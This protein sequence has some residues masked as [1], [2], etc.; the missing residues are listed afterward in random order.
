MLFE[1]INIIDEYGLNLRMPY[2]TETE[3]AVPVMNFRIRIM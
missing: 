3:L 1:I 2:L